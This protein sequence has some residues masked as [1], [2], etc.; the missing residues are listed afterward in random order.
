MF[1]VEIN[2]DNAISYMIDGKDITR[3][4]VHVDDNGIHEN[5]T[6]SNEDWMLNEIYNSEKVSYF[7]TDF[8]NKIPIKEGDFIVEI[9]NQ[10]E[11]EKEW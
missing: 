6:K 1:I 5:T 4:E 8:L 3:I 7:S 9:L 2:K 11:D 10:R